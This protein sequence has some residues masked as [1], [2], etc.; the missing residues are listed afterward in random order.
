MCVYFNENTRRDVS[1]QF[2]PELQVPSPGDRLPPHADQVPSCSGHGIA[3][4]QLA[5]PTNKPAR[6]CSPTREPLSC[7]AAG[8]VLCLLVGW[9][10]A[11]NAGKQ[12]WLDSSSKLVLAQ[13]CGVSKHQ[14][15][16]NQSWEKSCSPL[17]L[18]RGL[19]TLCTAI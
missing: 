16:I 18:Q 9:L 4:R 2:C 10:L 12:G 7:P 17:S 19:F 14:Q 1:R 15:E 11:K 6:C 5:D 13:G 3:S 8:T